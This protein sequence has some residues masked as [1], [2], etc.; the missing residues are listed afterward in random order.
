MDEVERAQRE[1]RARLEELA[2]FERDVEAA[3][4]QAR[5]RLHDIQLQILEV[6]EKRQRFVP[7][8]S[9][10]VRGAYLRA[11]DHYRGDAFATAE[12]G[13]C[14]GCYV[15]VPAQVLSELRA[16]S[17]LYRCESCGRFIIF[18]TEEWRP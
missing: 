3:N 14:A 6:E 10:Q 18:V 4:A 5:A 9:P 13:H 15:N 11:F 17:K 2:A 12:E 1:D 8:L 7:R 16:G